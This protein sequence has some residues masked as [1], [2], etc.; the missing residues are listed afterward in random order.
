ME[1]RAI[2]RKKD[3]DDFKNYQDIIKYLTDNYSGFQ[4]PINE[5]IDLVRD[6]ITSLNI[7][8]HEDSTF[9]IFKEIKNE[10]KKNCNS[11]IRIIYKLSSLNMNFYIPDK[12]GYKSSESYSLIL[13][14]LYLPELLEYMPDRLKDNDTWFESNEEIMNVLLKIKSSLLLNQNLCDIIKYLNDNYLVHQNSINERLDVVNR[15]LNILN[16]WDNNRSCYLCYELENMHP[17]DDDLRS[18]IAQETSGI[19]FYILHKNGIFSYENYSVI[20]MWLYIP[21]LLNY[22]PNELASNGGWFESNKERMRILLEIED[23]LLNKISN[24]SSLDNSK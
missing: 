9:S 16:N 3:E 7:H 21:E 14:W 19:E 23:K 10:F 22:M 2:L 17:N 13:A 20:T 15:L 18:R 6:L 11:H 24:N 5:R 12:D 8:K 1:F 4:I